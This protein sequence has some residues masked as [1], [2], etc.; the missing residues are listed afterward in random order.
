M[1]SLRRKNIGSAKN[2][3][4][5]SS[6]DYRPIEDYGLI[7][8]CHS[9]ALVSSQGSIDWLCLPNF[10]SPSVFARIL[11][12]NNGG[13]WSIRPTARHHSS[14]RY[15]ENTN[16]L[17]T[18]FTSDQGRARMMDFMP[19][20]TMVGDRTDLA[21]SLI[22]IVEGVEGETTLESRCWPRPEYGRE[23]PTFLAEDKWVTF[24]P[25]IVTGPSGWHVD[26]ADAA[27]SCQVTLG[28]GER[29]V[30]TLQYFDQESG[31]PEAPTDPYAAVEETL[32]FWRRWS[33][34]CTYEGPYRA[35]VV[36]SALALKLLTFRPT[37]AILAAPTTSLPEEIGG[38]RNWDYR[39]TW[40]RDASFTLYALLLAGFEK[41]DDAFFEWIVRTVTLERT[42]VR[43]LY[44]IS[45]ALETVERTLDHWAGYR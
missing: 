40:I 21:R 42:G 37:G 9:A 14:H 15:A 33:A 12:A 32:D 3:G 4:G 29:A 20:T 43:V 23:S 24:G 28:P 38:E 6:T 35:A 39:F 44:P 26:A 34:Q 8:D 5:S 27:I 16:V 7:G 22:R 30:F 10:D 2:Q 13:A 18:E 11:D 36:R 45:G 17:E 1:S 19:V 31:R 25:F 41:E